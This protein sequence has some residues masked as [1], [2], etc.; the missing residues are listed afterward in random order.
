MPHLRC[1]HLFLCFRKQM[2]ADKCYETSM[3]HPMNEWI[4]I[5]K[6]LPIELLKYK[7]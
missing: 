6:Q 7:T 4:I 5:N 1:P 3:R 2:R